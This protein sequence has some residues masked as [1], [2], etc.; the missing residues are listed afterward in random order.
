MQRKA[1]V[2]SLK[3]LGSLIRGSSKDQ[4]NFSVADMENHET[5]SISDVSGVQG[6]THSS[7]DQ[8]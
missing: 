2:C 7:S 3:V 1:V 6:L 4:A 8:K 5:K